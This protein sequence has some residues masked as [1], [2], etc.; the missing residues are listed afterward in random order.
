MVDF[1]KHLNAQ[2]RKENAMPEVDANTAAQ[3]AQPSAELQNLD[4]GDAADATTLLNLDDIENMSFDD[5]EDPP[6]FVT[7]PD[8][9]YDLKVTKACIEKYKT[10]D[11]PN[12]D[13]KR[14]ANY[15]EILR[16]VEISDANEQ[17]PK[18]G[19]KFSERFMQNEDGMKYW[20]GKA[21]AI[22]GDV[23]KVSVGNVLKELSTGNYEFRARITNKKSQGKKGTS[24]E[25]KEFTNTNVRVIA[26]AADIPGWESGAPADVATGAA[27]SGG[28]VAVE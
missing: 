3:N 12:V 18:A 5:I 14:F 28:D 23:G 19:D 22:L 8:G 16:V 10:K 24:N 20:K 1:S 13:H 27:T 15:Y 21:K 9:I 25:G 7:P 26:K 17:A 11:E 6:G 4:A 2:E